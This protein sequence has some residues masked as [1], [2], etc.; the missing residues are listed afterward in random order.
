MRG[1]HQTGIERASS[2]VTAAAPPDRSRIAAVRKYTV[3]SIQLCVTN[4]AA[5]VCAL[6]FCQCRTAATLKFLFDR[7]NDVLISDVFAWTFFSIRTL[8]QQKLIQLRI[9]QRLTT[10]WT[11]LSDSRGYSQLLYFYEMVRMKSILEVKF[12]KLC[13]RIFTNIRMVDLLG[14]APRCFSSYLEY[15]Q[16][17]LQNSGKRTEY[18]NFK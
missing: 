5:V 3:S 9:F 16:H 7:I 14:G 13:L 8:S 17:Y 2:A 10:C 15:I 18:R 6:S 11:S 1:R 12:F 4:D